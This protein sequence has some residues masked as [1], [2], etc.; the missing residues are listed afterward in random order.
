MARFLK[1]LGAN[2]RFFQWVS[3]GGNRS[4]QCAAKAECSDELHGAAHA[5]AVNNKGN[6]TPQ[7]A[8]VAAL[9]PV[10]R[11]ATGSLRFRTAAAG[12][13]ALRLLFVRRGATCT[14]F[15]PR[16]AASGSLAR[17]RVFGTSRKGQASADEQTGETKAGQDLLELLDVHLRTP[18]RLIVRSGFK[19]L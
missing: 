1:R 11:S 16:S 19:I 12:L 5:H 15:T 18:F 13:E 14:R 6:P 3:K 9:T 17:R 8:I 4:H 2:P 7:N 10:Y